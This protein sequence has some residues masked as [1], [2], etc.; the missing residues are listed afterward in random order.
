MGDLT[1][2]SV[3]E[4]DNSVN[5]ITSVMLVCYEKFCPLTYPDKKC[6]PVWWSKHLANLRKYSRRLYKSAY[7]TKQHTDW[8]A[9]EAGFR[10]YNS[11]N[12]KV[13]LS[14]WRTSVTLP[15]FVKFFQRILHP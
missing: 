1:R 12:K 11:E 14:R 5:A 15:D 4:N 3:I 9:Y 2:T 6:Q 7:K 13:S 10:N 8:E